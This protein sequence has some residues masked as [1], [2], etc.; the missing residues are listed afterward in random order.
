M[1]IV[2]GLYFTTACAGYLDVVP[3]DVAT[4]DHAF[5]TRN[6]TERFLVTCYSYLPYFSSPSALGMAGANE[7]WGNVEQ[8]YNNSSAAMFAQGAQ[9][10]SSPYFNAWDEGLFTGIRDC[11]IFL[12]NI[13]SPYDIEDFERKQWIAE[14]KFL[15]AYYHFYLLQ[16]Y[17]PIPIIRENL[18]INAT[19]DEVR[20]YREPVD[21]VTNYIVELIDEALPDLMLSSEPTRVVDAGRITQAIAAAVKAKVLVLAASPLLNGKENEAPQFSLVDNRGIELF[22]REYKA[23]KWERAAEAVRQAIE[24]SHEAGHRLYKTY[25]PS[26]PAVVSQKTKDKFSLRAAINV[27]FNREIIWPSTESPYGLQLN[28]I[29]NLGQYYPTNAIPSNY[30]PTLKVVEEFYTRH[31]IPIDEDEEWIKWIGGNINNCYEP[32]EISVAEGS[33]I[34]GGTSSLSEDHRYDIGTYIKKGTFE[35]HGRV[36]T[37]ADGDIESTAKLHFYR[38]PRFYA[39]IGFDRGIWEIGTKSDDQSYVLMTRAAEDQGQMGAARHMT[40]GYFTKKLVSLESDKGTQTSF[41]IT[42][43]MTY[44][45]IRLSDLYLL[46]AEALNET[47]QTPDAE[48]YRWI[49]SVRLR[50]GLETVINAWDKYA[51]ST[52]KTK[53]LRKDGMR[54]II[55]RERMIELSFESHKFFDLMRWKD[56]MQ[57]LSRPVQGWNYQGGGGSGSA[58]QKLDSYYTVTT[59]MSGGVFNSRNYFWPI[60]NATLRKNNNLKQNPGW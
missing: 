32:I 45:L 33:G 22:P 55:K 25:Q 17:G 21:D 57:Y 38:E 34:D 36:G 54:D 46:Y 50:A 60:A 9:N 3:D 7:I 35:V 48:V 41:A 16:L 40:C 26:D 11:N 8:A 10:A 27:K 19:I 59:Y 14:V 43:D 47:K 15:K 4:I 42:E 52:A 44:P 56:A 58:S 51:V 24:I 12:E 18:P 2:A 23:E 5:S 13:Y 39:W 6:T 30:G 49:D 28:M 20:V 53:P 37:S 1:L 29:P 31:G